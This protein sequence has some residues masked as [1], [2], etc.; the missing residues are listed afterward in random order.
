MARVQMLQYPVRISGRDLKH[1]KHLQEEEAETPSTSSAQDPL[2]P[3]AA[4]EVEEEAGAEVP[5]ASQEDLESWTVVRTCGGRQHI[6][7]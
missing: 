2:L 4:E 7:Q 3:I 6:R 1:G 5:G